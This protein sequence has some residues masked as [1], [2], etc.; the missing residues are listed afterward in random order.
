M[1]IIVSYCEHGCI[2]LL[3]AF[4]PALTAMTRMLQRF[5]A[6]F[7][8]AATTYLDLISISSNKLTK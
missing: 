1:V 3:C 4:M 7:I 8:P 6:N 5:L 2:T